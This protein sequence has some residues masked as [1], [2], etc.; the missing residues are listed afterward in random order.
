MRRT[1]AILAETK[2]EVEDSKRLTRESGVQEEAEI[3]KCVCLCVNA[4]VCLNRERH[5]D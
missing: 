3:E 1:G 2:T 5:P 4:C